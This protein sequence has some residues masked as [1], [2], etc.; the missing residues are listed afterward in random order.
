[1]TRALRSIYALDDLEPAA[2]RHLPRPVFAYVSGAAEDRVTLR[3]NRVAFD[4]LGFVPRNG[5]D[6]SK[7]HT[8]VEL[9]GQRWAAP[10]GIAPMGIS[11]LS[12][13]RGDLV[14]ARAAAAA[15]IPMILSGSSLIRMEEVAAASPGLWFQA[16]LPGER[17]RNEALID[18][19]ERAGF[20][21]LV[22]TLDAS[23]MP[24]RENYLR[25]GFSS[26]LRPGPRLA[27]DGLTRP[28]W[29]LGTALRTLLRHGM[30]HFENNH[31]ERG[32]PIVSSNVV[33]D[34]GSRDHLSWADVADVRRRWCGRLV[35]KG[36]VSPL[37][38]RAARDVGA[39]ALIVSNHGGRQLDGTVS[40][41][42]MLPA[43]VDAV[44][45]LPVLIDSGFRRGTHV[46]KALALG[47]RLVFVGRP[48][49]YAAA[50]AGQA[51]VTHAIAL[52]AAEVHRD[53]GML[54]LN[55]LAELGPHT[56]RRIAGARDP[57]DPV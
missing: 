4:E 22:L 28:R 26:P 33:R 55:S 21:T 37:D 15:R 53:L 16:Y 13:Y 3:E 34:F 45:T 48:F 11:A 20:E 56:L 52:L 44:G 14:Q 8:E 12:A 9:F 43:V 42:R 51:G 27:W 47:A 32:P 49:N 54:G 41:L 36:I 5:I 46:L 38:A 2:R 40:P 29:L 31:A 1:M 18:R 19:V 24:N 25:G 39:D 10:F 30:P 23:I 17:T 6:V 35:I 7:R 50:V 57:N